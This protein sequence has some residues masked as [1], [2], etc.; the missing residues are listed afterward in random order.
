MK[1]RDC[2]QLMG[3]LDREPGWQISGCLPVKA[4]DG[5]PYLVFVAEDGEFCAQGVPFDDDEKSGC[6][7]VDSK[8]ESWWPL[9]VLVV[10]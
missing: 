8:P 4:N 2:D 1:I 9:R 3:V 6:G 7:L 5:Q 10:T